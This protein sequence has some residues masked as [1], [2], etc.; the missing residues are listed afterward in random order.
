[1][2]WNIESEAIF[3]VALSPK[4]INSI[5][6]I[7]LCLSGIALLWL[8]SWQSLSSEHQNKL[9]KIRT[10]WKFESP[11][12]KSFIS[13]KLYVSFCKLICGGLMIA[14]LMSSILSKFLRASTTVMIGAGFLMLWMI[15]LLTMWVFASPKSSSNSDPLIANPFDTQQPT[16]WDERNRK[17]GSEDDLRL[18]VT[19]ITGYLGSGKTTLIKRI[20][21]N[22]IGMKVLVIENEIGQEGI[23][24]D[25]LMQSNGKEEI[26]L[27]NNGCICCTGIHFYLSSPF[28]LH[29]SL[30]VMLIVRNDLLQTFKKMFTN[31]AFA[32]LEWIIIE[33]TGLADPAPLI[34]SF[35]M[36]NECQKR[37]RLDGVLA[38]VDCKHFKWECEENNS[39]SF[40]GGISESIL[41]VTYADRI[42]LNKI[43]LIDVQRLQVIEQA[44]HRLNRTASILKCSFGII[45]LSLIL[46]I[47]AFDPTRVATANGVENFNFIVTDNQ[48][49]IVT[50]KKRE[51]QASLLSSIV[52]VSLVSDLPVDLYLFNDWITEI[53]RTI[54]KDIVRMKGI[55]YM[56]G[57]E[58]DC[59]VLQGV[60]MIF[61]G[62]KIETWKA[63]RNRDMNSNKNEKTF[64]RISRLVFIGI[65][66]N[67]NEL[68]KGFE[69]TTVP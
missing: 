38:I 8:N 41:Q 55:L 52:T 65:K 21:H 10:L 17:I 5:C 13:T 36:D 26:I 62:E 53:L 24:H 14:S 46:N 64:G 32:K 66:L 20:L 39:S 61:D 25:L 30:L 34:Q 51:K 29:A 49:K 27:L 58:N 33:T 2:W 59:F 15:G 45:E 37:L 69:S 48:G 18:P 42:L 9:L 44:I 31:D 28:C 40:H 6:M 23:D 12:L 19:I 16:R 68:K 67:E 22:T 47:H 50:G 56:K 1:M 7:I 60:H 35:Y 54:G 11:L 63:L 4:Q 3:D 43:D 57:Y